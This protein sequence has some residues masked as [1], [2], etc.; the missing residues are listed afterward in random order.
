MKIANLRTT[1]CN[2]RARK[3]GTCHYN[4]STRDQTRC[5]SGC[6]PSPLTAQR[7]AMGEACRLYAVTALGQRGD[8]LHD[9]SALFS[10]DLHHGEPTSGFLGVIS[11]GRDGASQQIYFP[12][13]AQPF[14]CLASRRHAQ[15]AL[16]QEAQLVLVDIGSGNGTFVNDLQQLH[17]RP[18]RLSDGDVISFGGRQ[19]VTLARRCSCALSKHPYLQYVSSAAICV[20][21]F[22]CSRSPFL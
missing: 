11:V 18:C 9:L 7:A 2:T 8:P 12:D 15:L 10:A 14:I 6:R 20:N 3:I 16:T 17:G 22:K 13:V 21:S 4:H 5:H 1:T 19:Q